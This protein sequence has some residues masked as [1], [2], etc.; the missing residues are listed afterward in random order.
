MRITSVQP[1]GKK[2]FKIQREDGLTLALYQGELFK[3][4]LQEGASLP[5]EVVAEIIKSILCK[6]AENR[7]LNIL[8]KK[9][10]TEKQLTDK[11]REGYYPEEAI[12]YALH[13]MK[14]FGYVDDERYACTYIRN[15]IDS[16]SQKQ[17][18][19]ALQQRGI[20]ADVIARAFLQNE[21]EGQVVDEVSQIKR[22]LD[23]RHFC[24]ETA[25][26]KEKAKHYAY[27][28]GKGYRGESIRKAMAI[29]EDEV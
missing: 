8:Q 15:R 13:R 14:D 27:L 7:L 9:D 4:H 18:R 24:R 2:R 17:I 10:Y 22:I 25:D 16:K 20:A 28:V 26:Y 12:H 21:E 29:A 23:K 5:D 11:L 3:Y 1:L 6:R 19:M